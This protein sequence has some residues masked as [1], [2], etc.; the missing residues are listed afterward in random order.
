MLRSTAHLLLKLFVNACTPV[1]YE[2]NFS[3]AHFTTNYLLVGFEYFFP[4]F[5]CLPF[6][7]T[8][9]MPS[10]TSVTFPATCMKVPSWNSKKM[11]RQNQEKKFLL[12]FYQLLLD[13]IIVS[14]FKWQQTGNVRWINFNHKFKVNCSLVFLYFQ[15]PH[16]KVQ[17]KQAKTS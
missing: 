4:I 5:N 3:A 13:N 7:C 8:I 6:D 10:F 1:A 11:V 2:N 17:L 12:I 9:L 15:F 16:L 14:Y